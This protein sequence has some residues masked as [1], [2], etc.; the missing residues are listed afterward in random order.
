[1]DVPKEKKTAAEYPLQ[2][3]KPNKMAAAAEEIEK[4]IP[5]ISADLPSML[6]QKS[7]PAS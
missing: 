1:M 3:Q 7:E 2:P 4:M 6:V 5:P